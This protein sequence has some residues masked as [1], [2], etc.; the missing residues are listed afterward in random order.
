MLSLETASCLL[1][2]AHG[3][4]VSLHVARCGGEATSYGRMVCSMMRAAKGAG[5]LRKEACW[6]EPLQ[7][8]CENSASSVARVPAFSPAPDGRADGGRLLPLAPLSANVR[9][10]LHESHAAFRERRASPGSCPA[11]APLG[12]GTVSGASQQL[13]PG[14]GSG[15]KPGPQPCT[16]SSASCL[17]VPSGWQG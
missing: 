17:L 14:A 13:S 9:R 7:T 4:F 5:L 15:A 2:V 12:V 11:A 3:A 1:Q 16:R 10:S 8:C 6:V